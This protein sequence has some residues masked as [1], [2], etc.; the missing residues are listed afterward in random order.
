MYTAEIDDSGI[1]IREPSQNGGKKDLSSP[2][3]GNDEVN[4]SPVPNLQDVEDME[5]DLVDE[6][7]GMLE[8][9]DSDDLVDELIESFDD[10]GSG[11]EPLENDEFAD[12]FDQ[13]PF[14]SDSI[15]Y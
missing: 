12:E 14:Y 1:D 3:T 13:E 9:L 15:I 7:S 10:D 8:P 11:I 4:A 6:G 5:V 2:A